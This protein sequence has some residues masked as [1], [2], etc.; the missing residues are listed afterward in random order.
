MKLPIRGLLATACAFALIAPAA[1]ADTATVRIEGDGVSL[2]KTVEVPTTGTFGPDNC[3]YDTPGGAIDVAVNQ[4]WDRDSFTQTILGETHNFSQDSDFWEFWYNGAHSNVGI[5]DTSQPL[6]DGDQVL[7]IVQHSGPA[8]D[9]PP[10]V[11]P[12]FI[13]QA[14][15]AVERDAPAT[16]T[17]AERTYSGSTTSQAPAAGV[18]LSGGGASATTDAQG[19]AT[20]TFRSA[21]VV[22][23]QASGPRKARS[24]VVAVTVTE[25][26]QPAPAGAT[27]FVPDRISPR[28]F[29]KSLR[30]TYTRKRAPRLLRGGV[31]E[32]GGVRTVKLR[33]NRVTP[34]GRCFAFSGKRERFV[35]RPACG[36]SRGWWFSIGDKADW[37]YQL[38]AKLG[39]GRYVLDVNAI[40]QSYNRDDQRRRGENRAVFTVR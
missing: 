34:G 37:E 29:F 23:V 13:T 21:G 32:A 31:S 3:A 22:N 5:C 26:G 10:T 39:P 12:L 18:T 30:N 2:T 24:A 28:A 16:F 9:Y 36:A 20:L 14:P 7:M 8:P 40:D 25:P 19:R 38:P 6:Q 27:G 35:R 33:L 17:V 11:E 4:N 15:G 1:S